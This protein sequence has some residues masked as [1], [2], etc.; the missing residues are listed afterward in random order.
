YKKV[1]NRTKPVATT[2]PEEFRIERRIPGDP[3]A[4]LPI[5]PTSPPDYQPGQRYT[6]ERME[7]MA[8]NKDEFLWPE[9]EKL[10][11]YLIRAHEQ[12]FAWTEQEKGKFSDAYFDPVVIPTIE[13]IPWVLRNIPIPPGIYD[14]VIEVIRNKID[15]GSYE[16]S[17][18]S[19]RSRWFCVLKKDGKSLRIVHD[20]QPLNAVT[21]K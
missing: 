13:H 18:S 2:L 1:A 6:K 10:V 9:E 12:A 3:L 19:Y 17:N 4:N 21:I 7:A 11:H 14:R 8:V 5:L 15:A 16:A 20:L